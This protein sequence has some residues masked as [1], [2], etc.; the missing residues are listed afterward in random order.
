MINKIFTTCDNSRLIC[1]VWD[2][3]DNPIGIVQIIHGIFDKMSTYDKLATFLNN[4][5]YIVFG[6]DTATNKHQRTFDRAVTQEA[7]IMRYLVNKY[8]LPI[9]LIGYGYGGFVAQS[10]LHRSD[11]P[12]SAVCLVKSGMYNKAV[13]RLARIIVQIGAK[14]RG[15]NTKTKMMNMFT[16]YHCG[17][18]QKSPICTY[19]FC[20]SFFDGLIKLDTDTKRD[21]PVLV[22]SNAAEHDPTTAQFSRALY[23]A[24]HNN[25]LENTT[26]LI[27]PDM[28]NKLLLEMNCGRIQNDILSFFND[29]HYSSTKTAATPSWTTKSG[30][31][32]YFFSPVH[33]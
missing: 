32:E 11:T 25:N 33:T 16:R 30:S 10:L 23:N 18:T 17:R 20:K 6:I 14:I 24:Y 28:Q 19:G 1:A 31:S 21:N 13:I 15:T 4:N 26:L 8:S 7:D 29:T 27:Y 3:V 5:G 22:I 2:S 9:F 12:I